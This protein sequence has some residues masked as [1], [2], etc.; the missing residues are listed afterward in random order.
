MPEYL[1]FSWL[2]NSPSG[3]HATCCPRIRMSTDTR[4]V[5]RHGFL[6]CKGL[7]LGWGWA[8]KHAFPTTFSLASGHPRPQLQVTAGVWMQGTGLL[9]SLISSILVP[10]CEKGRGG[11]VSSK[12]EVLVSIWSLLP[13]SQPHFTKAEDVLKARGEP[14]RV[15]RGLSGGVHPAASHHFVTLPWLGAKPPDSPPRLPHPCPGHPQGRA[16]SRV[17]PAGV[18][19]DEQSEP[20]SPDSTF[21]IQGHDSRRTMADTGAEDLSLPGD[22]TAHG[23]NCLGA[24]PAPPLS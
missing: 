9:P 17:L 16:R 23:P 10:L 22:H 4:V 14:G 18:E 2:C 15:G 12:P 8:L 7:V 19:T 20:R 1:S 24:L 11:F 3:G 21:Q 6:M 5:L 13:W